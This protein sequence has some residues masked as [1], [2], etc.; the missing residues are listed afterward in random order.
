MLAPGTPEVEKYRDTLTLRADLRSGRIETLPVRQWKDLAL[1]PDMEV[2]L[3]RLP[4]V[5]QASVLVGDGVRNEIA[6]FV[7]P[8]TQIAHPKAR[9]TRV[10]G[11][12]DGVV[13]YGVHEHTLY[14]L[15]RS[16][17]ARRGT[18]ELTPLVRA[19]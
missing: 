9:W 6:F 3:R 7:G 17:A 2:A 14:A 4:G 18:G 16:R 13:G 11:F 15:T 19:A 8:W 1:T 10:I 5:A 12:D